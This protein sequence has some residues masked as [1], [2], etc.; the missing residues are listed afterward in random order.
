M[1]SRRELILQAVTAALGSFGKPF[2]VQVFRNRQTPLEQD[3]LP[4]LL[5]YSMAEQVTRQTVAPPVED[6]ELT[7]RI[8]VRAVA[9][10][11]EEPEQKLDELLTWA[12][13]AI[14]SDPDL[15]ALLM[16]APEE[17]GITWTNEALDLVLAAAAIDFGLKYRTQYADRT[18][19]A[20]GA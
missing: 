11:G 8:E 4:A 10:V 18:V 12:V 16:Q 3:T 13:Y 14:K 7:L 1:D 6:R 5:V 19:P 9:D 2:G 15:L 20:N 17:R